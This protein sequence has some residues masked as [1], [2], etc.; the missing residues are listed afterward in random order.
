M[1]LKRELELAPFFMSN[2]HRFGAFLLKQYSFTHI[3]AMIFRENF[4][5]VF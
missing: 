4:V 2:N 3:S 5:V 1:S